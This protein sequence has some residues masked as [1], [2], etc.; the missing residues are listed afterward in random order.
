MRLIA[1]LVMIVGCGG[2]QLSET[3][4]VSS[5]E[6]ETLFDKLIATAPEQKVPYPFSHL[7]SFLGRYGTPIGVLTPLG[8]SLQRKAGYPDA[9]GDPRRLVGFAELDVAPEMASAGMAEFDIAS[10]LFLGYVEKTGTIEVLSI[11]PGEKEFSFQIVENYYDVETPAVKSPD[12]NVCTSCH[13]HGGPIFSVFP[14]EETN[15]DLRIAALLARHHPS[16]FVD[17]IRIG[18]GF[19]TPDTSNDPAGKFEILVTEAASIMRDTEIWQEK[20]TEARC[21]EVLLRNTFAVEALSPA[22]QEKKAVHITSSDEL[23]S[24][25]SLFNA[26][27][28]KV[29]IDALHDYDITDKTRTIL[30]NLKITDGAKPFPNLTPEERGRLNVIDFVREMI[31]GIE[32]NDFSPLDALPVL[33]SAEMD[34]LQKEMEKIL[35]HIHSQDL[36][37]G[38]VFDPLLPRIDNTDATMFATVSKVLQKTEHIF[39][40]QTLLAGNVLD[41]ISDGIVRVGIDKTFSRLLYVS[42]DPKLSDLLPLRVSFLAE[43]SNVSSC[44]QGYCEFNNM[45]ALQ[46]RRMFTEVNF[47]FFGD[48]ELEKKPQRVSQL[49]FKAGSNSYDISLLCRNTSQTNGYQYVCSV[50]D[51]WQIEDAV[52]EF[53]Q[54][55]KGFMQA[56]QLNPVSIVKGVLA[57]LGY[58]LETYR[59]KIDW[60]RTTTVDRDS[61]STCRY[62]IDAGDVVSNTLLTHCSGCHATEL[63]HPPPFLCAK[64]HASFCRQIANYRDSMITAL[65]E[66]R[67]PPAGMT[68]LTRQ[69][70]IEGLQTENGFCVPP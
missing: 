8:R 53:L 25:S 64:D 55:Q 47:S 20:C 9:F 67:M 27:Q 43:K 38:T 56:E 4:Q 24:T 50:Y 11:L 2:R 52:T 33:T 35:S 63:S 1:V 10:R 28:I 60:Q 45:R 21:R 5:A 16:G 26:T 61:E 32:G 34:T 41:V 19:D 39:H 31:A 65:R 58:T 51:L 15:S 40:K 14:W 69:T 13:Q 59:G 46:N 17:G 30:H 54:E 23:I 36:Y 66:E 62:Q 70:L 7:V 68:V 42:F 37:L 18:Y 22:P 3:K 48:T 12:R 49:T 29:H 6:R 44:Q 57:N